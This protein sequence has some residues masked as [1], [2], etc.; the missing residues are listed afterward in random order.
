MM[1][2]TSSQSDH[3]SSM[4][5]E[6]IDRAR[7]AAV[8]DAEATVSAIADALGRNRLGDVQR[9][10]DDLAKIAAL[11]ADTRSTERQENR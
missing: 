4:T 5:P 3:I 1:S 9:Y 7:W 6:Q 2:T 8:D 11:I 10:A